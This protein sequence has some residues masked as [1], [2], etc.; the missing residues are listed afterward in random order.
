MAELDLKPGQDQVPW[1]VAGHVNSALL[2]LAEMIFRLVVFLL[3]SS[4]LSLT[5]FA[6]MSF[7]IQRTTDLACDYH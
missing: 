2:D 3:C 4:F 5:S 1:L 6:S 7:D